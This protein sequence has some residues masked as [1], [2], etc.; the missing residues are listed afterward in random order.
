MN[1]NLEEKIKTVYQQAKQFSS[2]WVT[3]TTIKSTDKFTE[4]E[5]WDE[6]G[7]QI[8]YVNKFRQHRK[9]LNFILT[10]LVELKGSIDSNTPS[11]AKK[12]S[13]TNNYIA[14]IKQLISTYDDIENMAWWVLNYYNKGG[15]LQ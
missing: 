11:G 3:P 4:R 9:D 6:Y 7:K 2:T 1:T 8:D 12:L 13:L 10:L 5:Y 15:G 14:S